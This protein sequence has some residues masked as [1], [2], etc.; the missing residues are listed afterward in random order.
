MPSV[1]SPS[2]RVSI[3]VPVYNHTRF[4]ESSVRSALNQSYPEIE[5]IVWDDC[6]PDP[7][8]RNILRRFQ[9][10]PRV[11][12]YFSK[13]NEGISIATNR[14]IIKSTGSY[15]AFLDCDD[16]LP[17]RAI[18]TAVNYI[19]ANPQIRYFYSNREQIDE[20]NRVIS[21]S[22]FHEY[23]F[24][25]PGE[26]ILRFM[27]ASHLKIIKKEAFYEVGLFK[28]EFDSC[29][30]YDMALR[31]S[32]KYA[33]LH[34]PDYLYQYRIHSQQISEVKKREQAQLSYR[35]RDVAVIRRRIFSGDIGRKKI[36]IVMLTMNRWKRTKTTL[37]QL[38]KN[39]GLPFELII[40]DNNSSDD[41][42][43][44]LQ[45][46]AKNNNNVHLM[47]EKENLG[48]AGGRKKAVRKAQGDFIVTLD[49]D[50]RVTPGWLENL[51]V[52]LKEAQ[53]DAAC[54]KAVLPDGKIQY[55][56]G[57]YRI[58]GQFIVFSF[59]DNSLSHNDLKTY[60]DRGCRWL[61][62]GAA[63][64]RRSVFDRVDFC[65][66]LYGGLED[67][68]LSLQMGRA[69]IRMVNSPLS[70]VVHHHASTEGREM[71]DPLYTEARQDWGRLKKSMITFYRRHR[72]IVY[73]PWLFRQ[74]DIP[75]GTSRE[76]TGYFSQR[77]KELQR[78]DK[79]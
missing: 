52:R 24:K 73:D 28:K 60:I 27:F 66:E 14:A 65:E 64:Y 22:E 51:L 38:V 55:N 76:I 8:V 13:I 6:S 61:P 69:G 71:R 11:K 68:D 12:I 59:I 48:C 26:Q 33:F 49:N 17:P 46:F 58:S 70:L 41:T 20:R 75:H 72:L 10:T 3:I 30:D 31:M 53:A 67:N 54:C 1:I 32:E 40:L 29:Q 63:I 39:T 45:W 44:L 35:A 50:V 79:A 37:E 21:R 15:V 7:E 47:L 43:K 5:I 19:K 77:A 4:I 18:E 36:S 9:G 23:S 57:N 56:G 74:L 62:G 42:V 2:P 25:S 34:I 16:I 78:P